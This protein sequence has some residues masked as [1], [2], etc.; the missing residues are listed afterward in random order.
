MSKILKNSKFTVVFKW[1]KLKMAVFG[2]PNDQNWFHIKFE[3]KKNPEISTL[4]TGSG[5]QFLEEDEVKDKR[6]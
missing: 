1:S 5:F 6:V 3:W 4:C 2:L